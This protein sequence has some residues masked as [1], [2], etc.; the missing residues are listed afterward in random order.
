MRLPQIESN[1]LDRVIEFFNPALGVERKRNR[2]ILQMTGGGYKG[3]SR[4]S[5]ALS[6]WDY[7]D[8]SANAASVPDL[9]TLRARSRDLIRNNPLA[10]GAINTKVTNVVGSGLRLQSWIDHEYLGLTPEQ[11]D[12]WEKNAERE[13]RLWAMQKE[14]DLARTVNFYDMQDLAF[15]SVLEN[16][17]VFALMTMWKP[18]VP[19]TYRLAIQLIEADRVSNPNRQ[20][21]TDDLCGGV[22]LNPYGAPVAYHIS[23]KHPG[24]FSGWAMTWT[25]IPAFGERTGRR[26]VLHLFRQLRINQCRGIP[27]LAPVIQPLKQLGDYTDAEVM[28][29]VVSS[30]FTVFIKSESE[31]G[32]FQPAEEVGGKTSDKDFKLGPAAMLRLAPNE[33]IETTNPG[34]PNEKF[35]PFVMA[36]LR[37][38]GVGLEL[39]FELLV[40]HFTASY[41]A[42]RAALL[43]AWKFFQARRSW[44]AE[45]FCQP[46]YEAWLTEAV[47]TGR[48]SAPG[49]LKDPAIRAA[50][51][52]ALWIGPA[53]GQIDELKEVKAAELRVDMGISTLTEET[54]AYSGLSWEEIHAQRVKEHEMR[55]AAGLNAQPTNTTSPDQEAQNPDA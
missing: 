11:A 49:F 48:L 43:E 46:I 19:V 23:D 8:S 36:V 33:S 12:A 34:R 42:A 2:L 38:I 7:R 14:C 29:A 20:A 9:P 32:G 4:K 21:D 31:L 17:D 25:R 47:A 27:D 41:S 54:A 5:R 26:N 35:D 16:G 44:L 18:N 45:N 52:R 30:L 22:E 37:Q 6:S 55:E 24:G 1:V 28:A 39:P 10:A 15:R 51:A 13:F 3:A 40:K 53:K 50:Y